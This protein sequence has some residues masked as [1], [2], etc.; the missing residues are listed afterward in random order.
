MLLKDIQ[1]LFSSTSQNITFAFVWNA[2]DAVAIQVD[3]GIIISS[4]FFKFKECKKRWIA[5]VQLGVK[6]QNFL[7][8]YFEYLFQV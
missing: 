8:Q 4:F 2:G 1:K 3:S 5:D 6:R 7:P